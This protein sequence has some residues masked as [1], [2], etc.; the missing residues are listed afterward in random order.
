MLA[1]VGTI[2][3]RDFP[4]VAGKVTLEDDRICIQGKQVPVNRGTPALLAAA[5]KT[6]ETLDQPLPF[7]YLVGDIG[8][9]DGSRRLYAYLAQHLGQSDF[10]TITFHY[11]QPDVDWHNRVLFAVEEMAQRP[12]LIADAGFMYAAKMS[13]QSP[14]YDL[15]T[16]DI[17][18]LAF[19]A[20]EEAPHP[21]YTRGFILHEENRGPELIA[22]AYAYKNAACYLL[23]KGRQDY[24]ANQ[25]GIQA[26]IH[27]PMEEAMEAIGGTGDTLTGIVA[28]LIGAGMGTSESAITAAQVNRLAGHYAEPTPATQ[29]T[30]IIH[31]IPR[32]LAKVL[33]KKKKKRTMSKA[34]SKKEWI[35]Q[36]L[37]GRC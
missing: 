5:I 18:E 25:Q 26:V 36:P 4:L 1:V 15:F 8:L 17:G 32:A 21:F 35:R 22:R 19:L 37:S 12:I 20:D 3:D 11:L 23:V 34:G 7:G 30:E 16:P 31:H 2:P 6:G 29:V 9:G 28:V 24:L 33:D 10:S 14:L 27:S 13:G